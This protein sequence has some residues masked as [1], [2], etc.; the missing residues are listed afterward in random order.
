[1]K[2]ILQYMS[3]YS[4]L[5]HF[6]LN[7]RENARTVF[8][9]WNLRI[10]KTSYFEGV[11]YFVYFIGLLQWFIIENSITKERSMTGKV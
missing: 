7:I 1:M 4:K 5:K 9:F 8:D 2:K 11:N 6:F 3:K 10:L